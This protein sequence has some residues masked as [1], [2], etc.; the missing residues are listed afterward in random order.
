M[1]TLWLYH[2]SIPKAILMRR[3]TRPVLRLEG[4]EEGSGRAKDHMTLVC[5]SSLL[6]PLSFHFVYS[7]LCIPLNCSVSPSPYFPSFSSLSPKLP[8][9]LTVSEVCKVIFGG[10]FH[11]PRDA[12]NC[13]ICIHR[14]TIESN[15]WENLT[16][17]KRW[18]EQKKIAKCIVGDG[19]VHWQQE[20]QTCLYTVQ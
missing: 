2:Q 12:L 17:L 1:L 14:R 13:R 16:F 18:W 6:Q 10:H 19:E 5:K 15:G 9:R 11:V 8:P 4:M 3:L 20:M 7:F